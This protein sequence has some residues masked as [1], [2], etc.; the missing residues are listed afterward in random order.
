MENVLRVILGKLWLFECELIEKEEEYFE[1]G[2][3]F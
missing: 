3:G 2:N 1:R